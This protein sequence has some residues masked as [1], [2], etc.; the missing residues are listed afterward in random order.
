MSYD[1]DAAVRNPDVNRKDAFAFSTNSISRRSDD[2]FLHLNDERPVPLEPEVSH[3]PTK[4]WIVVVG[5]AAL[6]VA[7]LILRR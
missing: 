3:P 7:G 4:R 6:A 1:Q 2:A 5:L